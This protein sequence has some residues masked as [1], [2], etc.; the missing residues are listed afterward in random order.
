MGVVV[1]ARCNAPR[2]R[3]LQV[4]GEMVPLMAI[5]F[6]LA[7]VRVHPVLLQHTGRAHRRL[8][9]RLRL[10][11][12]PSYGHVRARLPVRVPLGVAV[13]GVPARPHRLRPGVGNRLGR[14]HGRRRDVDLVLGLDEGGG[15]GGHHGGDVDV[16]VA[17]QIDVDLP[18]CI[19]LL[20]LPLLLG[21]ALPAGIRLLLELLLP[22]ALRLLVL[23]HG[24]LVVR[25]VRVETDNDPR[26]A[27]QNL[28]GGLAP[29]SPWAFSLAGEGLALPWEEED[30][31]G[32]LSG[33]P[34]LL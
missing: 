28:A 34:R 21:P 23:L 14:G 10:T 20:P 26:H 8:R 30:S 6:L 3:R 4:R 2:P 33:R 15:G 16:I 9:R 29:P 12:V 24:R 31:P 19:L 7:P 27:C 11:A 22:L 5:L 17:R 25:I 18:L 13:D 32:L 1:P